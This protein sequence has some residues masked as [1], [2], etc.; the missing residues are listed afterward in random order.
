[1]NHSV[2][3]TVPGV[4]KRRADFI[5]PDY[6][7]KA[8]PPRTAT[9]HNNTYPFPNT[10]LMSNNPAATSSERSA[11]SGGTEEGMTDA[12]HSCASASCLNK[13]FALLLPWV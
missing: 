9:T 3:Y 5:K 11:S 2:S 8:S 6:I 13:C 7:R 4:A 10:F 12:P 1:M